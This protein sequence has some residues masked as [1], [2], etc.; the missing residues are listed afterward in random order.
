MV[1]MKADSLANNLFNNSYKETIRSLSSLKYFPRIIIFPAATTSIQD[2]IAVFKY[3][4]FS[5]S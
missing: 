2:R 5:L 3:L 4:T 1:N